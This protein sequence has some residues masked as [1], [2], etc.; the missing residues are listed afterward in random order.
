[1]DRALERLISTTCLHDIAI[2]RLA[3]TASLIVMALEFIASITCLQDIAIGRLASAASL[4]VMVIECIAF[5]TY[6]QD[7]AIG[8]GFLRFNIYH[9]STGN[10]YRASRIYCVSEGHGIYHVSTRHGY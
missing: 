2:G 4:K 1:M 8:Q 10:C 3:R 7:M 5:I 6:L 9:V